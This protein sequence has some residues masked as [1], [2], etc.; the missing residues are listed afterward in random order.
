MGNL[1]D[2]QLGEQFGG[3]LGIFVDLGRLKCSCLVFVHEAV[4]FNDV[5]KFVVVQNL[6][7]SQFYL[8]SL[9]IDNLF[10][11]L[12]DL[13]SVEKVTQLGECSALFLFMAL[14]LHLDSSELDRGTS[15]LSRN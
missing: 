1:L 15:G 4:L 3:Q 6:L 14:I 13:G 11:E 5:M 10:V 8:I 2:L 12:D 9:V 7:A